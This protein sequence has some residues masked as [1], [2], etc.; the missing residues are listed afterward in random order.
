MITKA[1]SKSPWGAGL[2]NTDIGSDDRL[3]LHNLQIPAHASN[4]APLPGD[5]RPC[6]LFISRPMRGCI[7]HVMRLERLRG[8]DL[9]SGRALVMIVWSSWN[10]LSPSFLRW[11]SLRW[12]LIS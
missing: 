12:I 10:M 1:L 3:A 4:Y 6:I 9:H 5:V 2:G 7:V 8:A 11:T